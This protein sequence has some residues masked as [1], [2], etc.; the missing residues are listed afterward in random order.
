M[1][2][3]WIFVGNSMKSQVEYGLQTVFVFDT[4]IAYENLVECIYQMEKSYGQVLNR[5]YEYEA[6]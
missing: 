6:G 5:R 4:L 1:E 2:T 3:Q